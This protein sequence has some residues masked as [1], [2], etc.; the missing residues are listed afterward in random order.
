M[1]QKKEEWRKA[2]CPRCSYVVTYHPKGG[3]NGILKCPD[4][5]KDF[6]TA[7]LDDYFK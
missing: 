4:C 2:R 1:K 7:R 6:R 3:F 5:G